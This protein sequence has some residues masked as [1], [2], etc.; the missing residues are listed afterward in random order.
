MCAPL[1]TFDRIESFSLPDTINFDQ[2]DGGRSIYHDKDFK[3]IEKGEI[4][5]R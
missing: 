2:D 1:V 5:K 3:D 4:P